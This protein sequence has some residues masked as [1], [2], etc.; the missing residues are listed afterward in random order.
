MPRQRRELGQQAPWC[1][2]R[3]RFAS[4]AKGSR[5]CSTADA[6]EFWWRR[7]DYAW[8]RRQNPEQGQHRQTRPESAQRYGELRLHSMTYLP[9][10]TEVSLDEASVRTE[11]RRR[12]KGC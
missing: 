3:G 11:K 7:V 2:S 5:R 1:R 12:G 10:T 8:P 4:D 6:E 9:S